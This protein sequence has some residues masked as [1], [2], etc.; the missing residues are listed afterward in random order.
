MKTR[1]PYLATLTAAA[2]LVAC[3][4]GG[5]AAPA[6]PMPVNPAVASSSNAGSFT[7]SVQNMQPDEAVLHIRL[8]GQQ[9]RLGSVMAN[10]RETF[11]VEILGLTNVRLEFRIVLGPTCI[12]TDVGISPG[13][14]INAVIPIDLNQMQAVCR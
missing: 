1:I 7:I 5:G 12:T 13:E 6:D 9:R 4:G 8:D 14:T 10:S 2:L 11:E 3:G